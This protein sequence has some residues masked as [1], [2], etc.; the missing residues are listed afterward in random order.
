MS[1]F[2]KV[3]QKSPSKSGNLDP[4][5]FER[6]IFQVAK[7][8]GRGFQSFHLPAKFFPS[9]L[10]NFRFSVQNI[11]NILFL[12]T[13]AYIINL[14]YVVSYTQLNKVRDIFCF[15]PN[16]SLTRNHAE[17]RWPSLPPTVPPNFLYCSL[18]EVAESATWLAKS[19][20][21]SHKVYG[22]L[23]SEFLRA[24]FFQTSSSL[25]RLKT[26]VSNY[27]DSSIGKSFGLIT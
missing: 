3:D 14:A 1:L 16:C 25:G 2:T 23:L 15:I 13:C 20:S 7:G 26:R 10:V 5:C 8:D 24:Y 9:C 18:L 27:L 19:S 4:F 6:V 12:L 22:K 11:I 21:S 17:G